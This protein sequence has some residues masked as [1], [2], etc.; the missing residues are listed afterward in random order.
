MQQINPVEVQNLLGNI[1]YPASKQQIIEEAIKRDASK[2]VLLT[3]ENI[4]NRVYNSSVEL[5]DEFED[6]Q[7]AVQIFHNRIYP[8]SKQELVKEAKNLHI[9][10]VIVKALEACPYKQYN[11]P[12]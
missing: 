7:K 2:E 4:P 9:R 11:S 12:D 5:I 10:G 1:G 6:F 3:L 8:A